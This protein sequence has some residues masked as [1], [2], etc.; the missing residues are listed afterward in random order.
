MYSNATP[1]LL[2]WWRALRLRHHAKSLVATFHTHGLGVAVAEAGQDRFVADQ[3]LLSRLPLP[4]RHAIEQRL[5]KRVEDWRAQQPMTV[6]VTH[7]AATRRRHRINTLAKVLEQRRALDPASAIRFLATCKSS[8]RMSLGTH[9]ERAAV[10][11]IQRHALS[12]AK[13]CRYLGCSPTE[14]AIWSGDGRMVSIADGAK[15]PSFTPIYCRQDV[16][17]AAAMVAS[18]RIS[19]ARRAYFASFGLRAVG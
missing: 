9:A 14:L 3:R 16:H 8:E 1:A 7:E 2:A 11:S 19:D 12:A 6:M 15:I 17:A 18:W 13:A 10:R 4:L 5:A